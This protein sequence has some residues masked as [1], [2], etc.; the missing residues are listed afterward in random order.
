MAAGPY[1]YFGVGTWTEPKG[2]F[3][4]H[5]V[6]G[7]FDQPLGQPAAA[8]YDAVEWCWTRKFATGTAVTFDLK[9]NTGTIAWATSVV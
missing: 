2:D 6:P 1:Q 8:E 7:L 5:W 3:S 4:N 9:I